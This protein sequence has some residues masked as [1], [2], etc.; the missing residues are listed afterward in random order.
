MSLALVRRTSFTHT[1]LGHMSVVCHLI[2]M[3]LQA[4]AHRRY[5]FEAVVPAT[6]HVPARALTK[7]FVR[8]EAEDYASI[9]EEAG[10]GALL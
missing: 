4:D 8:A 1:K 10:G 3:P 7:I 6:N 5:R 2:H 9:E